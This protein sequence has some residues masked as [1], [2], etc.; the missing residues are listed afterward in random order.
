MRTSR[1]RPV[2][3]VVCAFIGAAMPGAQ[4]QQTQA[5]SMPGFPAAGAPP[6]VTVLSSGAAPK[7]QLRYTIPAMQKARMDMTTTISMAMNMGGMAI[8][9]DMPTMK[10]SIDIGVTN[11]AANGDITYNMAFTSATVEGGAA[12]DP[13]VASTM[14]TALAGITSIKGTST[15]SSRGV[16][17]STKLDIGDP[18]MQQIIG[19]MTSSVE[20][21]SM[22]FPEEAVGAG[23]KWEVRQGNTTGGQTMFVKSTYELV[24]I[25]G[26]AVSLKVVTEQT[27]PPQPISNPALPAGAEMNLEKVTGSGTGTILIRLDSLVP[28]SQ[29]E[30]A[31]TMAMTMSM[32]GQSQPITTDMKMKVSVAPGKDK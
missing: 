28:T 4:T 25:D 15:V 9:M 2:L 27:A 5:L 29:L 11:I 26:N 20:N 19:Q 12:A 23:A 6:T 31:T 3:L 17:K 24:S 1:L 13:M 14:Q 30:S 16:T 22:P 7:K 21:L 8:P 18:A 10:M 32:G